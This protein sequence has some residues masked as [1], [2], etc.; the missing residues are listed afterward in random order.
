[1]L[2]RIKIKPRDHF[3]KEYLIDYGIEVLPPVRTKVTYKEE[4][5]ETKSIYFCLF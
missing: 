4:K 5:Y 2:S 1:M 3:R